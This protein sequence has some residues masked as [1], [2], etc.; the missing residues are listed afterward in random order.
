MW[1]APTRTTTKATG[2]DN[3]DDDDGNDKD[4][5][6]VKKRY[7]VAFMPTG[8]DDLTDQVTPSLPS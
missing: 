6:K 8:F 2:E 1:C 7:E 4:K 3:D 5:D